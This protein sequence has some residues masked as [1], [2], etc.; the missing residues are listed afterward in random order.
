M[1]MSINPQSY[2]QLARESVPNSGY[3][4]EVVP[5]WFYDTRTYVDATT[6]RLP[7]FATAQN[8]PSLSNLEL[9]G[10]LPINN[11]FEIH[12][13]FVDFI[14][15]ASGNPFVTTAAGGVAGALNDQGRLS[16]NGQGTYRLNLNNKTYGP[17]PLSTLRGT[18]SPVGFGWGTFTAEESLQYA[19][20]GN[21]DSTAF[22]GGAVMIKPLTQFNI[23]LE[24][25]TA[26]DLVND[27]LVRVT[28]QGVLSRP[29][30]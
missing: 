24:W 23:V 6:T 26:I 12:G 5:W 20:N 22:W 16:L 14:D 27:Y 19:S 15:D 3:E 13:I 25:G 2:G 21:P 28:M 30:S 17:F 9:S 18:G 11:Y 4:P 1:R 10:Q 7:F 29:V 8:D